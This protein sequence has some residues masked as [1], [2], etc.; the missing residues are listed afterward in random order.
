MQT[1]TVGS[2]LKMR[3]I[4]F[5]PVVFRRKSQAGSLCHVSGHVLS[6]FSVLLRGQVFRAVLLGVVVLSAS[7]DD[8]ASAT[9]IVAHRGE[10]ADAPENTLAAFRLAWERKVP[11]IELDVHLTKDDRLIV[12]HDPDTKRTTG[13]SMLIAKSTLAELRTLDA[14]RWKGERWTGEKLPTLEE[15]LATI[16][17]GARCFI[18]VKVGP[19]AVPALVRAIEESG[20]C[21]E[22]LAI[23]AFNAK[24][25]AESKRKLP[26]FEAYWLSSFR[27][28]KATG[29]WSPTVDELI[30][31]AKAI[32]ADGLDLS[33]QGPIDREFVQRVKAAKLKFFVWTVDDT[34]VARK[35]ADLG[36]DG[37]TTNR[38]AV[39][40]QQLKVVR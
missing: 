25:I 1:P 39:L 36:V 19:E 33:H 7:S 2:L 17:D 37:I 20:K 10:S 14:G 32:N 5:Q 34:I 21:P 8:H 38:G 15:A 28:D 12:C 4:G 9:E 31:Q 40:M 23:I 27:Q 24:T 26:Q 3:G 18:E 16:P 22:Q 29:A 6:K 13:T 30:Q 11:A 35:F